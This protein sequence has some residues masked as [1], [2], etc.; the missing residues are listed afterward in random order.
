MAGLVGDGHGGG[1]NGHSGREGRR[2][3][4]HTVAVATVDLC[5]V[6][7]HGRR[8]ALCC[9]LNLDLALGAGAY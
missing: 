8:D 4:R 3:E 9:W 2:G 7:L 6:G 1:R 5:G